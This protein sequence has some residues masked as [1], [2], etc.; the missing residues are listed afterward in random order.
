MDIKGF[1]GNSH[2]HID[3][4]PLLKEIRLKRILETSIYIEDRLPVI[5]FVFCVKKG[6]LPSEEE[7]SKLDSCLAI[8]CQEIKTNEGHILGVNLKYPI[9]DEDI[10]ATEAV[11]EIRKQ[12]GYSVIVHP[13][14]PNYL[15]KLYQLKTGKRYGVGDVIVESSKKLV[16]LLHINP[17]YL[18]DGIETEN[19]MLGHHNNS[20]AEKAYQ[21]LR[22]SGFNIVRTAGT[23]TGLDFPRLVFSTLLFVPYNCGN[24]KPD[25]EEFLR[26][27]FSGENITYNFTEIQLLWDKLWENKLIGEKALGLKKRNDL[28]FLKKLEVRVEF[29]K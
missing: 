16:L 28:N 18:P 3:R 17:N 10:S 29:R 27:M 13:F 7:L 9:D 24:E 25:S 8:P 6:D 15:E 22:N 11:R 2:Y 12:G 21:C 23:D 14:M 1:L 19:S 4:P 20:L 5:P 26:V